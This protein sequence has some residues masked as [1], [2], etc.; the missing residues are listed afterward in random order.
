M[1]DEFTLRKDAERGQRAKRLLEDELLIEAFSG[2]EAA[3]IQ[4]WKDTHAGNTE[5]REKLYLAIKV[6]PAV[7]ANL[8]S[9]A[10]SGYL[11]EHELTMLAEEAARK[12]RHA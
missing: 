8:D 6:L 2:L 12:R 5:G 1:T 10:S 3:Y 7:R 11:A 4:A 9:I